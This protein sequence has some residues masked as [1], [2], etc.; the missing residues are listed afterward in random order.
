MRPVEVGLAGAGPWAANFHA[1]VLAQ[2]PETRLAGVWA[3]RAAAGE[4]LAA[5]FGVPF[6]ADYAELVERSEAVAF[7]LPP[8]VQAG[9]ATAAAR[10]GRALLLDKPIA[11]DLAAAEELAAAV[12]A[13]GVVTQLVMTNR[14]RPAV[15]AFLDRA[16]GM[17]VLGARAC[18]VNGEFVAGPF[19]DS[20][21]R[22]RL[23]VLYNNAPHTLDLIDAALGPITGLDAAGDRDGFL[24]LTCRHEGGAVSQLSLCGHVPGLGKRTVFELYGPDGELTLDFAAVP[25][26]SAPTRAALRAEFAAAVRSGRPHSIDVRR[27][28]HLQRLIARAEAAVQQAAQETAQQAAQEAV[29]R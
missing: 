22:M 12:A 27:G 3:R 14:Y 18:V 9:L 17:R 21:W 7:A 6:Y 1:P 10:A 5:R 8:D 28:L 23:G 16:R 15:R 26:D 11:L 29:I 20:P 13:A 25:P 4:E 24:A 2:G 19:L